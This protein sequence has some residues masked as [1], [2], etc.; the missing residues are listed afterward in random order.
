MQGMAVFGRLAIEEKWMGNEV[1]DE[2]GFGVIDSL[3]M[4]VVPKM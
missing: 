2:A 4:V 3:Q 1:I